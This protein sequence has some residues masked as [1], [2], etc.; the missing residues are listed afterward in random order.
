MVSRACLGK[1]TLFN[2]LGGFEEEGC[3]LYFAVLVWSFYS[4]DGMQYIGPAT[5]LIRES[6]Q[7]GRP[8]RIARQ[9]LYNCDVAMREGERGMSCACR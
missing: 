7:T 4:V 5:A 3:V 9:Q 8:I 2:A 6:T 1:A